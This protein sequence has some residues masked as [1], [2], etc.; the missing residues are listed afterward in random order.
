MRWINHKPIE[1]MLLRWLDKRDIH[2]QQ[3]PLTCEGSYIC[4]FTC[5][6]RELPTPTFLPPIHWRFL[7]YWVGLESS[8]TLYGHSIL[9]CLRHIIYLIQLMIIVILCNKICQVS[10]SHWLGAYKSSCEMLCWCSKCWA[11]EISMDFFLKK[12][13][14]KSSTA[15]EMS[16]DHIHVSTKCL[17]TT[18]SR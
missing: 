4:T 11:I 10:L 18:L 12:R 2:K 7:A 6:G 8:L 15:P 16:H 3:F 9:H 1:V 5:V 14:T 13:Y 17:H